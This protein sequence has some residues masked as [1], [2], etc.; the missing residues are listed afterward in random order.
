MRWQPDTW[1]MEKAETMMP[2]PK[3]SAVTT[4]KEE[5]VV[6]TWQRARGGGGKGVREQV[7]WQGA[8]CEGGTGRMANAAEGAPL[9]V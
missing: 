7:V 3:A 6:M 9:A 8:G 5:L 4:P 1:P 2:M